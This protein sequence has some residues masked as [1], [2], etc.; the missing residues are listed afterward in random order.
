MKKTSEQ[1]VKESWEAEYKEFKAQDKIDDFYEYIKNK[2][3]LEKPKTNKV[4][5]GFGYC[6]DCGRSVYSCRC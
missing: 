1:I 3:S 2:Y 4:T 5:N 6:P